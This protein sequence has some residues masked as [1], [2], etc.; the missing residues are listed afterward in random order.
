LDAQWSDDL[1]HA[2]HAL[3]TEERNGY[4]ADFGSLEHLARGYRDA[5]VFQGQYS[6]FRRRRHGAPVADLPAERFIVFSQNHDQVG[7]RMLGERLTQLVDF[8][9]LKLAAACILL[10]PFIPVLFMGEE[11]G[12]RAPFQYFVSHTDPDLIEAVRRGRAEE[13]ASFGFLPQEAPDPQAEGTFA[14]CAL[15]HRL[16]ATGRHA[17]LL[18][19]Y[20]EVLRLRRE[21]P[22]LRRLSK[23]GLVANLLDQDLRDQPPLAVLSVLRRGG[24]DEVRLAFNFGQEPITEPVQ[25]DRW[26]VLLASADQRWG[27][28]GSRVGAFI[29]MEATEIIVQP[30]SC[31]VLHRNE[32]TDVA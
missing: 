9:S 17:Q 2:L 28:P 18:A 32:E 30:R 24:S 5:Y 8:E 13:F 11:Y 14:R 20:T 3:L 1:H 4:Y 23:K 10:S 7:N 12:E 15:D 6:Q 31:L 22:A 29:E 21:V 27:G 25:M 26:E 19:F 16:A